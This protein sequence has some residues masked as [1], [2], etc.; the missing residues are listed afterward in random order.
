MAGRSPIWDYF[1]INEDTK[2]AVYMHCKCCVSR[3]GKDAKSYAKSYYTTN[4]VNYLK[5][6][7]AEYAKFVDKKSA[8]EE[9]DIGSVIGIGH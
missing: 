6:H 5:E 2:F 9:A 8:T 4:L 1:T 7:Q 3:G